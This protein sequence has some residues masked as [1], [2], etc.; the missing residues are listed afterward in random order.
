MV[1]K[2]QLLSSSH[3]ALDKELPYELIEKVATG[4]Q[5]IYKAKDKAGRTVSIKAARKATL[6]ADARERFRREVEVC[7]RFE[8]PNLLRIEASGETE[9]TLYQVTEWLEG[10]D[11]SKIL[12][13][14]RPLTWDEKLAVME[15]ICAGLEYAHGQGVLHRD[16]K[17][18]NI[19][20]EKSGNA[21]LLDFGMARTETSQLTVAGLSPGTLT[22]MSP[23]QVRGEQCTAAS[24]IFCAGIVF[25]ELAT[26]SHPF[27]VDRGNV[28]TA[29]SAILF[30]SPTP[31]R[32]LAPDAPEGLDHILNRAL[33]KEPSRRPGS[34]RELKQT[35][36]MCRGLHQA[37]GITAAEANLGKT[38]VIRRTKSTPESTAQP[39]S[40]AQSS[41]NQKYCPSCTYPNKPDA[42]VCENCAMPFNASAVSEKTEPPRPTKWPLAAIAIVAVFLI[43]VLVF[44]RLRG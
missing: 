5:S 17:P 15:K 30:Q 18:A 27:V 8:H 42:A 23:E 33:E 29:L 3:G 20:L 19:F 40:A 31:L 6:S 14:K 13:D 44:L 41:P 28:G 7:S 43:A 1:T 24:D 21:R 36:A 39:F 35:I 32:Q 38:V 4:Q 12:K 9:Y 11:L 34:A 16:I 22:Y 26:G 10:E 37:G 25:Y 2:S